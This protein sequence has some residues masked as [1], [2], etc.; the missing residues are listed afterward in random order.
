[1]K[2]NLKSKIWCQTPFKEI[3]ITFL[4]HNEWY[5]SISTIK[6]LFLLYEPRWSESNKNSFFLSY[7]CF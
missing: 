1:M 5:C 6:Q 2:K 7:I 3:K 4:R